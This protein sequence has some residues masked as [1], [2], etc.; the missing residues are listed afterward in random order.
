MAYNILLVDDGE[1]AQTAAARSLESSGVTVGELFMAGNGR[2][3]LKCL[4]GKWVDIVFSGVDMPVMTGEEMVKEMK[5]DEALDGI[6]VVVI[7]E[8]G[9]AALIHRM[10]QMGVN[11][12]LRKPF[13]PGAMKDAIDSILGGGR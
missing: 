8:E 3:G 7:F 4:R 11:G 2:E 5:A 13:R 10:E 6:P 12:F 9:G 1:A